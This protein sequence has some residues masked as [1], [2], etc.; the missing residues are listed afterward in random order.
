LIVVYIAA[1]R[2][3]E[4]NIT[5]Y[6]R[7][8]QHLNDYP[9]WFNRRHEGIIEYIQTEPDFV[10]RFT[11]GDFC[12]FAIRYGT[13]KKPYEGRVFA[14]CYGFKEVHAIEF[15]LITGAILI[16]KERLFN[17]FIK[18]KWRVTYD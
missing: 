1:I 12:A 15:K 3:K 4:N 13:P 9:F 2:M 10:E 7:A 5:P 8:E 17:T 16:N 14:H 18:K 6:Q 11:D